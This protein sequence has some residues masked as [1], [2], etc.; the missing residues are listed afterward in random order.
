G[1]R[2]RS[3]MGTIECS[4]VSES[5]RLKCPSRERRGV[6]ARCR[7]VVAMA[8]QT[9]PELVRPTGSMTPRTQM[10]KVLVGATLAL[11][12]GAGPAVAWDMT[13]QMPATRRPATAAAAVHG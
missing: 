3:R 12:L 9:S 11:L 1:A 6:L 13:T 4:R 10:A 7:A 8:T 2:L 5:S